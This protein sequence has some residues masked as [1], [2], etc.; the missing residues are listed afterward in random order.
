MTT[1][2]LSS[3]LISDSSSPVENAGEKIAKSESLS[4]L[5]SYFKAWSP[6]DASL[7]FKGD[8][9]LKVSSAVKSEEVAA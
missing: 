5:F 8:S 4:A 7:K 2:R 9:I 6:N 1:P 3:A